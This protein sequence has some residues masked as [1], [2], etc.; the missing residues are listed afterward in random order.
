M[1]DAILDSFDSQLA[2]DPFAHVVLP[3]PLRNQPL[4]P[5]VFLSHLPWGRLL[6]AS[7]PSSPKQSY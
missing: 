5:T 7:V 2:P 3:T 1:P 6:E 4:T